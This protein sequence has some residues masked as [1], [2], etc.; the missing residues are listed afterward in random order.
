MSL[1]A[2]LASK[3][4]TLPYPTKSF[5]GQTVIVTGANIGLGFE[6][7]RHFVRLG[8]QKV[9]LACRSVEKGEE[10]RADIEKSTGRKGVCEV[11]A[12]DM[13]DWDSVKAFAKRVE[14]LDRV[15][16]VCENA[17]LAGFKFKPHPTGY[18]NCTAVNVIGT[19][20]LALNLLPILRKSAQKHNIIPRLEITSSGTH[21]AV[22]MSILYSCDR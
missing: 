9:I 4:A 19:F 5:A 13:G 1:M 2:M 8:A 11:W 17:G 16:V 14:G 12:V 20:L 3:W 21:A 10:A 22:C 15:D 7:S 18:D 6:A